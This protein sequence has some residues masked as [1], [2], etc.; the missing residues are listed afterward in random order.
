MSV[1]FEYI[2]DGHGDQVAK[3]EVKVGIAGARG[4]EFVHPS[5]NNAMRTSHTISPTTNLHHRQSRRINH[6]HVIPIRHERQPS[7]KQLTQPRNARRSFQFDARDAFDAKELRCREGLRE[8]HL[9]VRCEYLMGQW[10]WRRLFWFGRCFFRVI[11]WT[12]FLWC[13]FRIIVVTIGIEL[14]RFI[15]GM[16][17][18]SLF[19]RILSVVCIESLEG[20]ILVKLRGVVQRVRQSGYIILRRTIHSVHGSGRNVPPIQSI[21]PIQRI[22][23]GFR[24]AQ[25]VQ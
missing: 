20:A 7:Q 13:F 21:L 24:I 16:L 10:Q 17:R 5:P 11:G 4:R 15:L 14:E 3:V 18:C 19:R 8:D 12:F 9:R 23:E 22:V 6:V 1:G 2:Y 25:Q